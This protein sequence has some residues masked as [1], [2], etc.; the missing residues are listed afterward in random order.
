M[1]Q[2]GSTASSQGSLLKGLPAN[3]Y[4]AATS[5]FPYA[6]PY[7]EEGNRITNPGGDDMVKNVFLQMTKN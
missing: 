1:Q 3:L 7:D 5:Q 4:Y 2:Y 6:Q